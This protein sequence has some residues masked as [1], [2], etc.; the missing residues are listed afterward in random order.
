MNSKYCRLNHHRSVFP[1]DTSLL[2]AL[3]LAAFEAAKKRNMPLENWG[4]VYGEL[5]IMFKADLN[6]SLI[7]TATP[8]K[9]GVAGIQLNIIYTISK[10]I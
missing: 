5:S 7:K 9:K 4:K 6:N 8:L 1:N 3:Y 10:H 2:K